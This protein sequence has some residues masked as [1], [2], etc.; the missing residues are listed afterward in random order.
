MASRVATE[1]MASL[2]EAHGEKLRY[3][4]VG[5]W[6]T[7]FGYGLFV[8]LLAVLGP[9]LQP[10]SASSSR[11]I[12]LAGANYYIVVQWL[13]WV[14]AVPQSTLTMKYF[15]F[16][17]RGRTMPQILRA[18]G[19][20]LPAQG[21][22]TVILWFAV[23][24]LHLIPQVGALVAIVVTTVFSYFGHKYFTFRVPVGVGD[25]PGDESPAPSEGNHAG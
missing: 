10:L 5:V 8:F 2:Y 25:V 24:V 23:E 4:I 11:P 15:A 20:Y 21:L 9:V 7:I 6:N 1:R 17:Q 3:L 16:R 22:S 19:I 18:Y 13:G 12:A 14:V